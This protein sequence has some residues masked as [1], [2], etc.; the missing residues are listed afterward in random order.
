MTHREIIHR[1]Q[2]GEMHASQMP[3]RALSWSSMIVLAAY[4]Y[5]VLC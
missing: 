3:F 2:R 5:A 1:Q 4:C